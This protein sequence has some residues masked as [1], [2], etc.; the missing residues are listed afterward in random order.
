MW[1]KDFKLNKDGQP[2]TAENLYRLRV[3]HNLEQKMS[4]S[5]LGSFKFKVSC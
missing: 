1:M 5:G 3:L 4:S 2:I